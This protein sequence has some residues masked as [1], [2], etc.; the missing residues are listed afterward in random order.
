MPNFQIFEKNSWKFCNTD[1]KQVQKGDLNFQK[2]VYKERS[3]NIET[4]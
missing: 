1:K 2:K 3:Y 4:T